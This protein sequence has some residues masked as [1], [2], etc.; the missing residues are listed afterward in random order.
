[1]K[2]LC[3]C[4]FFLFCCAGFGLPHD[5]I[6]LSAPIQNFHYP[7]FDEKGNK[8]W[9]V[10]SR[11]AIM[12]NDHTF[13]AKN[14]TIST[15]STPLYPLAIQAF[16]PSATIRPETSTIIG[17]QPLTV[18]GQCFNAQA[19]TWEIHGDHHTIHANGHIKVVFD[20]EFH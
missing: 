20:S 17:D 11:D 1:M 5:E 18:K 13:M 9:E 2:R 19:Q 16:S 6:S 8:T 14:I 4:G 7:S 12:L 15:F 10:V 3:I